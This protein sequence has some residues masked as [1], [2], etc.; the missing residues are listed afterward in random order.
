MNKKAAWDQTAQI[1]NREAR[2]WVV[3][4]VGNAE[5]GDQGRK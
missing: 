4:I 1:T 2:S 3:S 5:E